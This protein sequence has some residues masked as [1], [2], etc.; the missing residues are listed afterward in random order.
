[1]GVEDLLRGRGTYVADV[2]HADAMH[3][4]FVRAPVAHA[5][6]R[7]ID[8]SDALGAPGVA[9]V[10]TAGDLGGV[11]PLV[12]PVTVSGEG[13][14]LATVGR[15][16]LCADTVRHVGDPVA[17]VLAATAA[18][19]T[20]AAELVEVDY[21]MLPAVA[22]LT[23]GGGPEAPE[24]DPR[25]PGN[26][27]LTW[28]SLP[29]NRTDAAFAEAHRIARISLDQAR[30]APTPLE[31]RGAV[32]SF[33]AATDRLTLE[34]P[35][36]GAAA[37]AGAIAASL[38][39]EPASVR[40]ITRDVGGS[41][42]MKIYP[43]PEYVA[44][45]AA[46]IA[47]GRTVRWI[48]S[49]AEALQSDTQGREMRSHAEMAL[50]A[51][52]RFLGVRVRHEADFGA[53]V[54]TYAPHTMTYGPTSVA[55]GLYAIPA[56]DVEMTGRLSTTTWTDA[57]RGA[58]KPE[59][60]VVLETL[61][62]AAAR[63]SGLDPAEIRRRNLIASAALPA[64]TPAGETYDSGDFPDRLEAA[65]AEIDNGSAPRRA[66]AARRGRLFGRGLSCWL[67]TTSSGP[68]D[69]ARLTLDAQ[70]RVTV[71]AG[72]QD[73]GQGH[74][75]AFARIVADR[76]G[77]ALDGVEQGDSDAA[78]AG[79][80]SYGAKTMAVMGSAVANAA[81][82]LVA[83]AK[84]RAAE[85]FQVA[86]EAVRFERGDLSVPGTNRRIE[87]AALAR[88]TG[89]LTAEAQGGGA[90]TYPNGCHVCEVE[91]DPETGEVTVVAYVA[92]DDYGAILD[93][94]GLAGQLMGGIAQGFGQAVHERIVFDA[95]DAQLVT[96]SLMDYG[97]PRASDMAAPTLLLTE[98]HPCRT[99]PAGTKGVGQAGAIAAPAAI[100]NA[101]ND[102]LAGA[103]AAPITRL[104]ATP[105][106]VWGALRGRLGGEDAIG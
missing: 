100:L 63:V 28:A 103:G 38:G 55:T 50:D 18:Q 48:A 68:I 56:A 14:R 67:D 10:L 42:G 40:V 71:S 97:L 58:G 39:R 98:A 13:N 35:T 2:A 104:P 21:D 86:P 44:L 83:L 85:R 76:T 78:P 54:S 61:V 47:T 99:T 34:L 7:G 89:G 9:A 15:P 30:V 41:F 105:L 75:A 1:M 69:T 17:L 32:V 24:I 37:V 88:E 16:I 57:Y 82:A 19:A 66:A 70:G 46:A 4:V 33:D 51:D 101:I 73:T 93:R 80:G 6:I 27:A 106:A 5:R 29:R 62:D 49:R 31:T 95:A 94:A 59:G 60:I 12:S 20:D 96:G 90:T 64:I 11:A 65:L 52:G 23:A 79:G 3:A 87:L 45:A 77:L 25:A 102:A 53:Y 26:V 84:A 74:A 72:S 43:Y 36:Q 92:A 81:D 8:T 91:I 22:S